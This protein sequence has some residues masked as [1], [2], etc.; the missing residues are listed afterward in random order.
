MWPD[1]VGIQARNSSCQVR[2]GEV[3]VKVLRGGPS[4]RVHFDFGF[5]GRFNHFGSNRPRI[6]DR[7]FLRE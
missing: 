1:P 5:S 6:V 7:L 3:Q 4:E 2:Q